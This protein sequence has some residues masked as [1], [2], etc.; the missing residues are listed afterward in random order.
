MN[1]K[2]RIRLK[3]YD[4]RVLDQSVGEIVETLED[5][6][7]HEDLLGPFEHVGQ[8]LPVELDATAHDEVHSVA[9]EP[10]EHRSLQEVGSSGR[11]LGVTRPVR[12]PPEGPRA[13][14]RRG[15]CGAAT[16]RPVDAP[17]RYRVRDRR[18]R[19]ADEIGRAH[20]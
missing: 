6:V 18:W 7:A 13:P 12:L 8:P 19:C 1:E 5:R 20:V 17:D 4:H 11:I 16:V 3:A 9:R 15:R 10:D 14:R 2:I